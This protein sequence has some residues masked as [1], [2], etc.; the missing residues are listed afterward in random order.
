MKREGTESCPLLTVT[1]VTNTGVPPMTT[2]IDTRDVCCVA[3]E[4]SKTSWV[5]AFASPGNSKATVHKIKTG[6]VDRLIGILKNGKA[7]AEHQLGRPMQIVLCYEVGYDG[8]WLARF[9]TARDIRTVVFDPASFLMPRRGRRAKTDRLDA[10]GMTRTLRAWLAGDRE[11]ARDVHIPSI[12]QEDAKRIERER[13][14]LVEERVSIVGRIKGLLALHGIWLTGKRIG[15]GLK[16]HLEAM[17]TGDGRPLAPF[18]R[19]DIERMLFR[20]D[21]VSQQIAEVEAEGKEALSDNTGRFPNAEKVRHLSTLGAVGE[22]TAT[23]LV[24]EVY[25]R[26]FETRRHVASFIGLAPTPYN[27][28]DVDRDRGISKAG[29]KLARQTLVELAW[30]WLRYQPNS[31][32][33]LWWR[34]RF[35]DKGM[36]GRKVGI[37]A[38]ARKLAIALWRFVEDGIVPEGATLKV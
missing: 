24:A 30:F 23:V 19:R 21:L 16:E 22:T 20:Y 32:L 9:L 7:K 4:L 14:C 18:L 29:N 5:C 10:E 37:V 2:A 13:K 33:S 1:L 6:D 35:G 17:K 3:L 27:S 36:R 34:E 31:K 38:L 8:F 25:H 12:E 28:G 11:M 15:K 26:S